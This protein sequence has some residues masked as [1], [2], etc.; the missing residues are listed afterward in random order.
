MQFTV[1]DVAVEVADEGASLMDVLREQLGICSVKDGCSPQGQ[2]GCCTVWVDGKPRVSCVTP[3]RRV[4]GRAITTIEGLEATERA[5]WAEAFCGSGASQ[6]GFCT[7]GIIMRLAGL[8]KQHTKSQHTA[9]PSPDV[10]GIN[11]ALAAHLC[12]CTGWRTILNAWDCFEAGLENSGG[13]AK[14]AKAGLGDQ[15]EAGT[16]H[17]SAKRDW[18][19]ASERAQLEGGT[20]QAVGPQVALGQGGFAADA[21][22]DNALVALLNGQGRWVVGET[23]SEARALAGRIQGRRTPVAHKMPLEFPEGDW[24][25][26]LR[27]SW[28]EPAYL[29]TDAAWCVP[30]AEPASPLANGG[31]FGGKTI[32][33]VGEVARSLANT[34]GRAVRVLWSRED[35]VRFGPKRPPV[36]IGIASDGYGVM[37]VA[38]TAGIA[39]VVAAVAPQLQI[40]EADVA[41]PPTSCALRG[42][43]WVEAAVALSALGATEQGADERWFSS[44]GGG[45]ATA[46]WHNG[47]LQVRVRCGVVLDEVVLR[48]YCVGAAH[49]AYSWVTSEALC[50]DTTGE[51]HDLTIRSFGIVSAAKMPPVE[52]E[53]E[54]SQS[55]PVNGSD[56]VFAAVAA[57]TWRAGGYLADWP[58]GELASD[59]LKHY[60]STA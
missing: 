30:G 41:G 29:E 20:P 12:R 38:R 2:C 43:G 28:V 19:A 22:P 18:A 42:A 34:H 60:T 17:S 37:R 53:I 57:E 31:A 48:S 50:V 26:R 7:P 21:A 45:Q 25:V 51:I 33:P 36:A 8:R 39:E 44:P 27:T 15:I 23:L 47:K 9:T 49:M 11:N 58:T 5:A 3:A 52:V 40:E 1:N 10:D 55:R 54:T 6:C 46:Q 14:D 59:G 16:K 32:S 13:G 56:A 35:T 4:A 24:A